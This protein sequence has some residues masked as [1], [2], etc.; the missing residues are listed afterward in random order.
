MTVTSPSTG[1]TVELTNGRL[2]QTNS[3]Q[4]IT[5]DVGSTNGESLGTMEIAHTGGDTVTITISADHDNV[6]TVEIAMPDEDFNS[7]GPVSTA[8]MAEVPE[9]YPDRPRQTQTQTTTPGGGNCEDCPTQPTKPVD[10]P[11]YF[12]PKASS[13]KVFDACVPND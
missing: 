4:T 1:R 3:S 2:T 5:F 12:C 13:Q 8:V 11:G 9:L 7:R 6:E 10:E